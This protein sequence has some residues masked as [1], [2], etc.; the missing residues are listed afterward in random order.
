MFII[1]FFLLVVITL[2]F[3]ISILYQ[4]ESEN[5][6]KQFQS[7]VVTGLNNLKGNIQSDILKLILEPNIQSI[8]KDYDTDQNTPYPTRELI[9][10][11]HYIVNTN[12]NIEGC[13]ILTTEGTLV[14]TSGYANQ[15]LIALF[16]LLE[17]EPYYPYGWYGPYDIENNNGIVDSVFIVRKNIISSSDG[18]MLGEIYAYVNEN[19]VNEVFSSFEKYSNSEYL[20]LDRHGNLIAQAMMMRF[21]PFFKLSWKKGCRMDIMQWSAE[22]ISLLSETARMQTNGVRSV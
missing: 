19:S 15:D 5:N 22:W 13:D 10:E 7:V 17:E 20:I 18:K 12:N 3:S 6:V 4:R 1:V 8:L 2:Y 16:P 9:E 11:I 21:F 14:K